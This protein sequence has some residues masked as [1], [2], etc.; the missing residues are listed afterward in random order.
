MPPM[1]AEGRDAM[2]YV[3]TID[4]D[5]SR[6]DTL[7]EAK[8]RAKAAFMDGAARVA[9]QAAPG[10]APTPETPRAGCTC[11]ECSDKRAAPDAAAL[12]NSGLAIEVAP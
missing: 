5:V 10:W 7:A 11:T 3:V 8:E 1:L 9:I 6:C 2:P 4:G 12:H